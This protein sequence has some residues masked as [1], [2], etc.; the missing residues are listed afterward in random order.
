MSE[1]KRLAYFQNT[2]KRL[3][4]QMIDLRAGKKTIKAVIKHI[5]V[6]IN[7]KPVLKQ[8]CASLR[9]NDVALARHIF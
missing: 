4:N 3:L 7:L 1:H 6:G 5:L 2:I 8:F 9:K